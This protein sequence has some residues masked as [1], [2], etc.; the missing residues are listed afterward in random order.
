MKGKVFQLPGQ[1]HPSDIKVEGTMVS[2]D[3]KTTSQQQ[4]FNECLLCARSYA[5]NLV[6]IISC[7]P[8]KHY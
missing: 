5:K 1:C 7:N 3:F 8:D 4:Q 2:Y 6:F